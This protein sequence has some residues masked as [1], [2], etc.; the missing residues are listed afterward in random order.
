HFVIT[1]TSMGDS[2]T[3]Q[4]YFNMQAPFLLPLEFGIANNARICID[5][6]PFSGSNRHFLVEFPV[7]NDV[8][9]RM[10]VCFGFHNEHEIILNS[11]CGDIQS[12]EERHRNNIRLNSRQSLTIE[13]KMQQFEKWRFLKALQ[14]HISLTGSNFSCHCV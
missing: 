10:H 1:D 8:S 7:G 5:C 6:T 14:Y 3:T 13:C 11:R 9:F 2:A 12:A 4:E